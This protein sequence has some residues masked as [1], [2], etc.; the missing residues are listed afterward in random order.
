[1]NERELNART[2]EESIPRK[3][4]ADSEDAGLSTGRTSRQIPMTRTK[5]TQVSDEAMYERKRVSHLVGKYGECTVSKTV[6]G[7]LDDTDRCG[8]N[9]SPVVVV[10]V[11]VVDNS[12][13]CC[14]SDI[15]TSADTR[16][17]TTP[18]LFVLA[19]GGTF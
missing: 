16:G 17:L 4:V 2:S 7:A 13:R 8:L 18:A 1:M 5:A 6:V 15:S 12:S 10:V 14:R 9:V 11:V 3:M 19:G